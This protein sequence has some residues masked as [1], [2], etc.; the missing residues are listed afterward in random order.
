MHAPAHERED[1]RGRTLPYVR[2][3]CGWPNRLFHFIADFTP[4]TNLVR[5]FYDEQCYG[6]KHDRCGD[7]R[8]GLKAHRLRRVRE[9]SKVGDN[10]L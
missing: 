3:Q 4:Q 2:A 5:G 6:K 8:H 1:M 10:A 7:R 9:V